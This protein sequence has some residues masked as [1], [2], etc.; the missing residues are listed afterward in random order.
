MPR[1]QNDFCES[2]LFLN[3]CKVIHT[4]QER[5]PQKSYNLKL[6]KKRQKMNRK[7]RQTTKNKISTDS[8]NL[9]FF[10]KFKLKTKRKKKTNK[11]DFSSKISPPH[12]GA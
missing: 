8:N 11:R 2:F 4:I 3:S 9:I 10:F 1:V 12:F 6:Y 7:N 5:L